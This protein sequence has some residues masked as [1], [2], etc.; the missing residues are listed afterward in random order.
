ML[1]PPR[2]LNGMSGRRGAT[3]AGSTRNRRAWIA[4]TADGRLCQVAVG[5]V[6]VMGRWARSGGAGP[7]IEAERDARGVGGRP[8]GQREMEALA[9][10]RPV[11]VDARDRER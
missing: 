3:I 6:S 2:A 5:V 4:C 1:S 10:E 11:T 7:A 9:E 8:I